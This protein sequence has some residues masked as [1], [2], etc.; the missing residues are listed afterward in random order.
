MARKRTAPPKDFVCYK[1]GWAMKFVPQTANGWKYTG[2]WTLIL[3]LPAVPFAVFA[4]AVDDTPQEHWAI[5]AMIPLFIIIGLLIWQMSKWML[6]RS[7][8]IDAN[9]IA[10]WKRDKA[11]KGE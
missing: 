6:A 1:S 4:S 2:I 5:W 7:D 3:M 8:V 9:D 11:R 10:Q